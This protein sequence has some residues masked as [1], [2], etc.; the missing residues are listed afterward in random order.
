MRGVGIQHKPIEPIVLRLG[1]F[2]EVSFT[3][4][5]VSP[6]EVVA[7]PNG[8]PHQPMFEWGIA[9]HD[10][11]S[12]QERVATPAARTAE[13]K[14]LIQKI[15]RQTGKDLQKVLADM[16]RDFWL[17][18][19][20]AIEYGLVSRVSS[21]QMKSIVPD[22]TDLKKYGL[23]KPAATVRLGSG[24]SQASLAI[25][26]AAESGSVYAKDLSRPA[27]F[28]IDSSLSGDLT[29]DASEYRQRG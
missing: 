5:L 9:L 17:S 20:E 12:E 14:A 2:R 26:S 1:E 28:T 13:T 3:I 11:Y 15:A 8:Q 24:S 19:E 21:V 27:V 25:G 6:E 29:K 22:A 23:E 10:L 16:E 18:A 4:A 7:G